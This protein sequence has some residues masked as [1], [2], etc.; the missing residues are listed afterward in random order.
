MQFER[1]VYEQQGVGLGLIIIKRLADLHGGD[2]VIEST[3]G[4]QT[5]VRLFLPL[6]PKVN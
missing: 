5:T 1:R 6:S 2:L 4:Q 3:P